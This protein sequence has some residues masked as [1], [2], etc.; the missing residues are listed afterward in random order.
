METDEKL[1]GESN[2]KDNGEQDKAQEEAEPAAEPAPVVKHL[3]ENE[4]FSEYYL[5]HLFMTL[6]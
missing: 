5:V 2:T 4:L 6:L 3:K 1:S